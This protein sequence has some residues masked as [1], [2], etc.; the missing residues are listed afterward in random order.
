MHDFRLE[1]VI[2]KGGFGKVN[3]AVKI[4]GE[5][6]GAMYALK[7][8][9]LK[10]AMKNSK[11]EDMLFNERN[12]LALLSVSHHQRIANLHYAFSDA[13]QCYVVLDLALGGD[14]LYQSGQ[15]KNLQFTETS[16]IFY[17]AQMAEALTFLHDKCILHRDIKPENMLLS[18]NGYIRL[19]DFGISVLVTKE[20][21][22]CRSRSGT[23]GYMAPEVYDGEHGKAADFFALGVTLFYL[24]TGKHPFVKLPPIDWEPASHLGK[25]VRD[26]LSLLMCKSPTERICDGK[27]FQQSAMFEK[28][29][30][31]MLEQG[32][33]IPEFI[34]NLKQANCNT[35]QF[36]ATDELFKEKEKPPS[37]TAEQSAC[38][39]L[40]FVGGWWV[41]MFFYIF[42]W[43][44]S[45]FFSFF[46]FF[47]FSFFLFSSQRNGC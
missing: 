12:L 28:L 5:D 9:S 24:C 43:C 14:L 26:C 35:G 1:R 7:Q 4:R 10:E 20:Q 3:A 30:W 40:L 41:V 46:L 33:I 27:E 11:S 22:T 47:F 45:H 36:D 13:C 17:A 19:T 15:Q 16:T 18:P 6:R 8:L 23:K 34:P 29:N 25:N 21:P 44:A 2:G 38:C 42:F 31:D 32:E 37:L 39:C